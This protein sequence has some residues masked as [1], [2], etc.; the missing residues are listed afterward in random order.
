MAKLEHEI[1][2]RPVRDPP[3]REKV[4]LVLDTADSTFSLKTYHWEDEDTP[5][6]WFSLGGGYK[7]EWYERMKGPGFERIPA[8]KEALLARAVA[9]R[10]SQEGAED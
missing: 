3:G 5:P 10:A 2:I 8:A 7:I 1:I 6:H 9:D 4:V